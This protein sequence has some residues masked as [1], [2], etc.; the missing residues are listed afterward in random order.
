MQPVAVE[1]SGPVKTVRF[2]LGGREVAALTQPPWRAVIDFGSELTPR[3]LTA[4]GFDA[5]GDEI[6]RAAQILNL[7]RP[8]GEL[9]IALDRGAGRAP[10]GATLRWR[11]LM[12]KRPSIYTLMLDGKPLPLD[13]A[14]HAA[15][16]PLDPA[17]P[18]V[19]AAEI[20][21]E[22]GFIARRELIIESVR[23][24]SISTQLTPVLVRDT[25][26]KHPPAWEGCLTSGGAA[27][28]TAA[29]EKP[30]AVALIVRDPD[31]REVQNA[32]DPK[33]ARVDS[34]LF[35]SPFQL[36]A[37]TVERIIWPVAESISNEQHETSVLFL[38]SPQIE[39][40]R[41]GMLWL[42]TSHYIGPDYHGKPR[43]YADAVAVA[44]VS[45]V[46]GAQRRAVIL[47][48]SGNAD[49]SKHQPAAVR[50]YLQSIG[51]PLFVWSVT[52]P[53]RDLSESW[54]PVEDV[55]N[56]DRLAAAVARLRR[57][58]EEQRIAW[59]NVDPLAALRL[60]ANESC[61]IATVAQAPQ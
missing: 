45:A 42:L 5:D 25:A 51:V 47:V 9:E 8:T 12:N 48:L 1:V 30:R 15:F 50:R 11:H 29:V 13:A 34:Q 16:P 20:H 22:D 24:D 36:D 54:G 7:P 27:V 28:R 49:T 14:L 41:A 17:T 26:R 6:A 18:H 31:F 44:G 56:L 39:A 37:D 4:I 23:S 35:Q 33:R 52:G 38:P 46:T 21:F 60:R 2:M 55:S 19:V 40:H 10:A 58:L 59:V 43:Q 3:E 61:G 57:T 53:R 32:L